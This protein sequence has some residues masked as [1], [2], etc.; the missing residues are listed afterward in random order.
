MKKFIVKLATILFVFTQIQIANAIFDDVNTN[1]T[2][3]NAIDYLQTNGIINGYNDGTFKPENQVNRVEFLKI[4]LEGS[5]IPLDKDEN[6]ILPFSDI[7]ENE[8]YIPYLKKAFAEGYIVG[9]PDGTFKPGQ[10]INKAEAIKILGE[11]Q[12]WETLTSISEAPFKDTPKLAWYSKYV[13]Y[14]KEHNYLEE[15]GDYFAPE[16]LMTRAQISEVIYRTLIDENNNFQPIETSD[17]SLVNET[18]NLDTTAEELYVEPTFTPIDVNTIAKGYFD[19]IQITTSLTN[20]FYKN[21]V[22]V[23]TGESTG[24]TDAQKTTILLDPIDNDPF[25]YEIFVG[26]NNNNQFEIPVHF[27]ES[28]NFN[29]GII[30]GE[31][32]DTKLTQISV[33]PSIPKI[34]DEI[35]VTPSLKSIK[36][37]YSNDQTYISFNSNENTLKRLT[38]KQNQNYV[39]YLSRQDLN[40]VTINYADFTD[41]TEDEVSYY[42]EEAA[43]SSQSPLI[44]NSKFISSNTYNFTAVEH[45]FDEILHDKISINP[46]D[47]LSSKDYLISFIGTTEVDIQ[48]K[49]YITKPNGLVETVTLSTS[50]G[51]E[52]YLSTEI[53]PKES[54]IQ[55]EYQPTTNGRYI[56]EIIDK[57][58]MPIL[59]HPIYIGDSIPLIPDFF[60]LNQR[61]LFTKNLNLN[62]LR[63][64]LLK[65]INQSRKDH[66]LK[67]V[68]LSDELNTISQNHSEDMIAYNFF[69]HINQDNQSPEDRRIAAGIKTPISENIAKDVSIEFSHWGLMRSGS[70]RQNILNEAWTLVGLGIAEKDGYLYIT[71]EFS[72]SEIDTNDIQSYKSELL[73]TINE[74]RS[75]EGLSTLSYNTDLESAC[76]YLNDKAIIEK[77]TLTNEDLSTALSLYNIDG[78]ALYIGRT[79]NVWQEILNSIIEEEAPTITDSSWKKIGIDI[80]LDS[81]GNLH[82]TF[83]INK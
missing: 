57:N 23:I 25:N 24:N 74:T 13:D 2:N 56:A 61:S 67:T 21:E 72:T 32:G 35:D 43:I 17:T 40:K 76:A 10:T 1:H 48:N 12:Q 20:T 34:T 53:I 37:A 14:A 80:Q 55:F 4:I 65:E 81:T 39:T 73:T 79:F 51:T 46:P 82:T 47:T 8:W 41:F 69:G 77:I 62:L 38:F 18:N 9:Y 45:S 70:H 31:T 44:R 33:L 68:Q 7:E 3:F 15:T 6:T 42:I 54:D 11:V 78:S 83:M 27:R 71:E 19:N 50:S 29:L 75:S 49:G 36:A 59:N 22:Y 52:K 30:P 66:G 5:N 64:E 16:N 63:D 58:G 26:E 28:G 60:D